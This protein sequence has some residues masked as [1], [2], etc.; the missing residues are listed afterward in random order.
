MVLMRESTFVFIYHREGM[1]NIAEG[2]GMD[3]CVAY[4]A[5]ELL[6]SFN[7]LVGQFR[8]GDD[9]PGHNRRFG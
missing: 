2:S 1:K 7:E 4:S 6:V 5:N 8:L 3:N 9:L